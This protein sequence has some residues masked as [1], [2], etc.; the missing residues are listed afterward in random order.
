MPYKRVG[1]IIYHKIGGK[2]SIKQ[3]TSSVAN[4]IATMKLLQGIEHEWKPTK[5]R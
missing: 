1:K 3:K 5:K 4:A 2:W